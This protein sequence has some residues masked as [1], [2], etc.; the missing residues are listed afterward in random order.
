MPGSIIAR[1]FLWNKT[2]RVAMEGAS[3][4][5]TFPVLG[6]ESE[7]AAQGFANEV[8]LARRHLDPSENEASLAMISRRLWEI[9]DNAG[10][11]NMESNRLYDQSEFAKQ[12]A[13]YKKQ[14][15]KLPPSFFFSSF[16]GFSSFFFSWWKEQLFCAVSYSSSCVAKALSPDRR[17]DS[18]SFADVPELPR[19]DY[20]TKHPKLKDALRNDVWPE[21]QAAIRTLKTNH[22]MVLIEGVPGAGKSAMMPHVVITEPVTVI[23]NSAEFVNRR[24]L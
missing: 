20:L 22:G 18:L 11:L 14:A 10:L 5:E 23:Y 12:Q 6:T 24:T 2:I 21:E 4:T 13:E 19:T 9:H 15:A 17:V 8:A 3:N 16:F 7:K 1:M